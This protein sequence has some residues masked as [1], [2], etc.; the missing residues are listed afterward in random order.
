MP[1]SLLGGALGGEEQKQ[2]AEG[3]AALAFRR[4]DAFAAAV[5]VAADRVPAQDPRAL[6]ERL[7]NF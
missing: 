4:V 5:A 6:L 3:P 2:E 7:R 1:E